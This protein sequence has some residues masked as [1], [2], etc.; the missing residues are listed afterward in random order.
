MKGQDKMV[1]VLVVDDHLMTREGLR[2]LLSSDPGIEVVGDAGSG[3][4]AI[5]KAGQQEPDV[6][7][8]DIGLPGMNGIEATRRIKE[9]RPATAVIMIT[10]YGSE[11]YVVEA[12]RAGAAGYL[13]KDSSRRLLCDTVSAVLDGASLVGSGLLRR[14]IGESPGALQPRTDG[15][16]HSDITQRMPLFTDRLTPRELDV[17]R[18]VA[19]GHANKEIAAKLNVAEYTV[20]KHVHNVIAKLNVYDRTQAAIVAVKVGL[21]D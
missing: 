3:E 4:E 5:E 6:V 18:L 21:V 1:Q 15:P 13:L 19:Q 10:A 2:V 17:L 9:A 7:L 12:L 16:A 14:A 20:K 11:T 8:M